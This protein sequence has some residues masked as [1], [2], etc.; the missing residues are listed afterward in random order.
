MA[1]QQRRKWNDG[2]YHQNVTIGRD[3]QTGKP[4]RK[5]LKAKTNKELDAKVEALKNKTYT[6]NGQEEKPLTF[7]QYAEK[8]L[9]LTKSDK[10]TS[11]KAQYRNVLDNHCDVIRNMLLTEITESDIRLQLQQ[12][13]A[14]HATK[15]LML[16]TFKQVFQ[17]AHGDRLVIWNPVC[18]IQL[19]PEKKQEKRRA[20]THFELECFRKTALTKEEHCYVSLLL[21][22]G[23][24]RGEILALCKT[25]I[26]LRKREIRI[27]KAVKHIGNLTEVSAPKTHAGY[28]TIP[29]YEPLFPVLKDYL[30]SL[31]TDYLFTRTDTE[32]GENRVLNKSEAQKLWKDIYN[33]VNRTARSEI[34]AGNTRDVINLDDPLQGL[35]PHFFRHNLTTILYYSGLDVKDVSKQLGHA[36]ITTTLDT[37]THLDKQKAAANIDKVNHYLVS[38]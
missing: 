14:G 38:Y 1:K 28:R 8:W 12:T 7:G 4:I 34:L 5:F 13:A 9:T 20:L 16:T 21:Y 23:C 3:P 10:A 11:T 25:D 15:E 2:F 35:T 37:Y 31:S 6:E 26:N 36:S 19:E 27:H 22:T 29:I 24:R 32:T 33:K 30:K 18:N 17:S